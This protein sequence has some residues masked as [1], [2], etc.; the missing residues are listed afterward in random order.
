[1]S[2]LHLASLTA[3]ALLASCLAPSRSMDTD[4]ASAPKPA[5]R[6]SSEEGPLRIALAGLVHQHAEGLLWNASRRDDLE[7]VGVFERDVALFDRLAAKHGLDA[8]LRHDDL[9]EMLD[10]TR[11]EAVSVM[12]SIA[13]HL[14]TIE[15]CAPRGVHALV[16]KPLAFSRS[17]AERI[18]DLAAEHG[19]LVLTNYETSWYPSV[20]EAARLVRSGELAPLR[21][22][23]FR[24]GHSGPIEIGCYREFTDWLTDPDENGG[25]ALVDFGCYGVLLATWLRGGERPLRVVAAARSLE[26]EVYG[27]VD[28]DATIVL[29]YEDA[30]AVVQASWQWTHDVKEMDLFTE[31]GSLH[32]G[33]GSALSVRKPD[34]DA[35]DVDAPALEGALADE[36]TYLREVVRGR[37][38]VDRLSSLELNVVVVEVLEEALRD[39]RRAR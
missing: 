27:E 8:S 17:D 7:I 4:A 18:A 3:L 36:W 28:D 37:C 30:T 11:P 20:R 26:P 29:E 19:V 5:P 15:E 33:R 16:E 35:E 24:H 22:M 38:A 12:T 2:N 25:G 34:A 10:R 23:V 39:A 9:A 6:F 21:R 1:M 14:A 32:V 31:A 13:D